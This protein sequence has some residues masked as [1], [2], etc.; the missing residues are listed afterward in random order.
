MWVVLLPGNKLR[1][2]ATAIEPARRQ[3]NERLAHCAT[4]LTESL[5]ID[6]II[7]H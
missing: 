2:D 6:I 4:T 5:S 3:R 7:T 1:E